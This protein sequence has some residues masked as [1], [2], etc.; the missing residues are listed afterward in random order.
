MIRTARSAMSGS[1]VACFDRSL[2]VGA[3]Q[4]SDARG[5]HGAPW[6]P[7]A[8][9]AFSCSSRREHRANVL[10]HPQIVTDHLD[11]WARIMPQPWRTAGGQLR[12]FPPVR[13]P[14]A[15]TRHYGR[16]GPGV[17][18]LH[19]T[20]NDQQLLGQQCVHDLPDAAQISRLV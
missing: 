11:L 7:V 16:P 8:G 3:G 13:Q 20:G 12:P 2:I 4:G 15:T 14:T 17:T 19:T 9:V 6:A 5:G 18:H 1:L 10:P